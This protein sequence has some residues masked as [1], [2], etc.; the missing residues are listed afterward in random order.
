MSYLNA[1][2]K[3]IS[4]VTDSF[5]PDTGHCCHRNSVYAQHKPGSSEELSK[6]TYQN[7]P[8]ALG[9]DF[10]GANCAL[11]HREMLTPLC[12]AETP[13][14]PG[15]HLG[16]NDRALTGIVPDTLRPQRKRLI[17]QR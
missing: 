7:V 5:L 4:T 3:Y 1:A 15:R 14:T 6:R 12:S 10:A 2:S 17:W 9:E 8:I 16:D 11:T 13:G